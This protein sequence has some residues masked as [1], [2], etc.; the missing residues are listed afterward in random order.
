MFSIPYICCAG[1]LIHR[2]NQF[3]IIIQPRLQIVG[4]WLI[5]DWCCR[6]ERLAGFQKKRR[7]VFGE[8][9]NVQHGQARKPKEIVGSP[10]IIRDEGSSIGTWLS[11]SS[12]EIG[13]K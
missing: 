10:E 11:D 12:W 1:S 2:N 9:L 7:V 5:V 13:S 3:R 4:R 6:P 8:T